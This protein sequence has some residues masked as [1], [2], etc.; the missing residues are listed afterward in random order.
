MKRLLNF[1][2]TAL[3]FCVLGVPLLAFVVLAVVAPSAHRI[4][5]ALV[6]VSVAA[7]TWVIRRGVMS[8]R[9]KRV[10]EANA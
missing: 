4:I 1:L 10:P 8:S 2:S 7:M 9:A 6:A 3:L 5:V